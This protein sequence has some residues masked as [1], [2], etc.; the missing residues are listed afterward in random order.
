MADDSEVIKGG[1]YSVATFLK[2]NSHHYVIRWV[3]AAEAVSRFVT[4]IRKPA[5][6][7]GVIVRVIVTDGGD[8]TNMEWKFNEGIVF[9]PAFKGMELE[10]K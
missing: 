1:E 9:P 10:K 7:I 5:A 3:D 8:H 2:D 6:K 4:E